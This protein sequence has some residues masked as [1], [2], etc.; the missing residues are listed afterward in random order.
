MV[1]EIRQFNLFPKQREFLN[2][3]ERMVLYS[4]GTGSSKSH[5]LIVKLFVRASYPETF[6]GMVRKI[7]ADIP[8][9]FLKDWKRIIPKSLYTHRVNEQVIEIKGGGQIEMF[10]LDDVER[11]GSRN[12]TGCAIEEC[13]QLTQNDWGKLDSVVRV[14][15]PLGNQLYG[16]CNPDGTTHWLY[17]YFQIDRETPQDMRYI[18]T[19]VEDGYLGQNP[20]YVAAMKRKVGIDRKRRYEGLWCDASGL[21]FSNF[22]DANICERSLDGSW[23][24]TIDDGDSLPFVVLRVVCDGNSLHIVEEFYRKNVRSLDAK[25][26]IVQR[27]FE[28]RIKAV[29]VDMQAAH[30]IES[31]WKANLPACKC[32]KGNFSVEEGV[33]KMETMLSA[34]GT[35]GKPRLTIS[36]RCTN[37]IREFRSWAYRPVKLSSSATA[38]DDG[39]AEGSQYGK[40]NNHALDAIRYIVKYF[41]LGASDQPVLQSEETAQESA[42]PE[43][44]RQDSSFNWQR[45][46]VDIFGDSPQWA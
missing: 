6:E 29:V 5:S 31:L 37:T 19:V 3:R 39:P 34:V 4:G 43:W 46:N 13:N 40:H 15:H 24:L 16:V 18:P 30:V 41:K 45:E 26:E 17:E 7:N 33:S 10:G 42:A 2:A 21:V 9:S 14:D 35:G 28:P 44:A 22:S 12:L 32:S 25:T 36:P 1:A 38:E 8:N 27:M 20:S 11:V 23:A